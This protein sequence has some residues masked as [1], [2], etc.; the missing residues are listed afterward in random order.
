MSQ[1][2]FASAGTN[3]F[4]IINKLS[5]SQPLCRLLKYGSR[6]PFEENEKQPDI[7]GIELINNNLLLVPK[8]SDSIM[9]QESFVVVTLD[10][11]YLNE[12]NNEF[13]ISS[14]KFDILCPYDD[15]VLEE[16]SLRPL[17]IMEEI[18]QMFNGAKL[19]SIGT[20]KFVDSHRLT[21]SWELGGYSM[22]YKVNDF[23]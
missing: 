19:Q 11:F 1:K 6:T 2:R 3:L 18:D 5:R 12:A 17:L 4:M 22:V 15:W 16:T 23:N 8:P 7:D 20:L 10:D 14:I 13:K 9:L 21:V